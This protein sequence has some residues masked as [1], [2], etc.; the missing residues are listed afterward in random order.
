[1]GKTV[2]LVVV[3]GQNKSTN[4][5]MDIGRPALDRPGGGHDHGES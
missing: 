3:G 5:H 1:M 2:A 4:A